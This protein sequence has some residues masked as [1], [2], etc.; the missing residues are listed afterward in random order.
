MMAFF[1]FGVLVILIIQS[2]GTANCVSTLANRSEHYCLV[3]ICV[4]RKQTARKIKRLKTRGLCRKPRSTWIISGKTDKWWK[5]M[6]LR[7]YNA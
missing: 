2:Y 1:H 6:R 5:C 4:R 3:H 7:P